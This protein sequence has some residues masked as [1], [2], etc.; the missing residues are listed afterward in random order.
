M[1][2]ENPLV[3]FYW[4]DPPQSIE[5]RYCVMELLLKFFE[6][7]P[8]GGR[9]RSLSIQ[10]LQNR[11][12][13]DVTDTPSFKSLLSSLT[14][15]ELHIVTEN[16]PSAPSQNILLPEVEQFGDELLPHWL[17]PSTASLTQ[18]TLLGCDAELGFWPRIDLR[19]IEYP[20]L[21]KLALG[22]FTFAYDWQFE[23]IF[24]HAATLELLY[25]DSCSILYARCNDTP[26]DA[27]DHP[28]N[29]RFVVFERRWHQFF[30]RLTAGALPCLSDFRMGGYCYGRVEYVSSVPRTDV[31]HGFGL[32]ERRLHDNMYVAFNCGNGSSQF[33]SALN[34]TEYFRGLPESE[35]GRFAF[36]Q[37]REEDEAAFGRLLGRLSLLKYSVPK[38]QDHLD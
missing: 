20:N 32:L 3:D 27:E 9:I 23:W 7:L 22:F 25:L 6:S 17:E 5:F 4:G 1:E 33:S 2:P 11:N 35:R 28:G 30:D 18:L 26:I 29:S 38:G 10:G 37:C 21:R 13:P 16:V 31:H 15:L 24:K 36:P 19:S 12:E 14:S 34:T 8:P